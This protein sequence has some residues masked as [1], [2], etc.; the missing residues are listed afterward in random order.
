MATSGSKTV[1]IYSWISLKFAWSQVS[2]S[3]EN[4]KELIE[5]FGCGVISQHCDS[6]QP[7]I[8]AQNAGIFGCGYNSNMTADAY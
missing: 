5:S 4:N 2:Q 3:I 6:A 7:Q 1:E 8:A